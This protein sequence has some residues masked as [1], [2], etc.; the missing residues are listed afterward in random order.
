MVYTIS[1]HS[2]MLSVRQDIFFPLMKEYRLTFIIWCIHLLMTLYITFVHFTMR[3]SRFTNGYIARNFNI[4]FSL[5]GS[6]CSLH[7]LFLCVTHVNLGHIVIVSYIMGNIIW[8]KLYSSSFQH[9]DAASSIST[10]LMFGDC[11]FSIRK[12]DVIS[13]FNWLL[14][15]LRRAIEKTT[16][17]LGNLIPWA[18]LNFVNVVNFSTGRS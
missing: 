10:E 14:S 9:C 18:H 8:R 11:K 2:I 1:V 12:F 6:L 3:S 5:Y 16:V 4:A 15:T 13:Q 7:V 17:F